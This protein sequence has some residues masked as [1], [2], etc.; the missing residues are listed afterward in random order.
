[1]GII[2][3]FLFIWTKF[4]NIAQ[5]YYIR[6]KYK[7]LFFS[8]F[9]KYLD[10]TESTVISNKNKCYLSYFWTNT[11]SD[12][13]SGIHAITLFKRFIE[14]FFGSSVIQWISYP[15]FS[16][17][18]RA[19]FWLEKSHQL[20]T[21]FEPIFCPLSRLYGTRKSAKGFLFTCYSF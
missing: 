15:D 4:T 20:I 13:P 2:V 5:K 11:R 18:Q 21:T 9:Q 14:N 8:D 1:M 6:P 7:N 10:H 3:K 19:W 12:S 17:V 16:M